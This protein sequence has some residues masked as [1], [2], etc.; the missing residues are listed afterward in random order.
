MT[1]GLEAPPRRPNS[2]IANDLRTLYLKNFS[3]CQAFNLK[4]DQKKIP[5]PL[6]DGGGVFPF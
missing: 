4:K 6:R 1:Y 5:H 3:I 2:L